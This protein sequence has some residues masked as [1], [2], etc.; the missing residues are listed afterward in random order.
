MCA[1]IISIFKIPVD[2]INGE[3]NA[4][5]TKTEKDTRK[6]IIDRFQNADGFG[7]IVMSPIAAGVGLTVVGANNVIH[8]ERHWNPA[9]EAQATDR[10]YRIR[11]EERRVGKE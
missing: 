2:V 10:V 1:L 9:K 6:S 8:L 11:S 4:T 5:P 7:V 3:V